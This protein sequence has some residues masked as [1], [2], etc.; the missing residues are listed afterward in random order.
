MRLVRQLA[1]ASSLSAVVEALNGG[2]VVALPTDTIYGI[3]ALVQNDDAVKK[4]YAIK[5]RDAKKPIAVCVAEVADVAKWGK[6]TVDPKL[7][8]SLLPGAV[9]V[10]FERSEALNKSFNPDTNLVGVRVPDHDFIRDVC[11]SVSSCLALTIANVRN[12]RSSVAVE[13]FESLFPALRVVVDGGRIE[14]EDGSKRL[15][16]T[17]V[18][19]S[20][21]GFYAIVRDGSALKST[22]TVLE[23]FGLKKRQK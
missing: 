11:R 22:E 14:D 1:N 20:Q 19:L 18:D 16:S 17:V 3:A 4:L 8:E 6:V 2:H 7:L 5:G 13:E 21:R 23:E 10:I 9:T 12:E 15:G